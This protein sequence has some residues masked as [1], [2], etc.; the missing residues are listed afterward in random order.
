MGK[1]NDRTVID[2]DHY[3]PEYAKNWPDILAARH[4]SGCPVAW[5]EEHGGYWVLTGY[6][7]VKQA[8]SSPDIFTSVNDVDG[9]RN[10]G[11]GVLI[12]Q[13]PYQL[14]LNEEDPPISLKYRMLE[15]PFFMPKFLKGWEELATRHLKDAINAVIERGTCDLVADIAQPVT[16]KTTLHIVGIDE[17][18]WA[19]FA[20]PAH[21]VAFTPATDPNYP[22][23]AINR[24]KERLGELL[25]ERRADPRD[26]VAS[27]LALAKI[28]DEPL[29]R[30]AA[31]NMLIALVTGGFDTTVTL[32]CHSLVWLEGQPD[33]RERML[34]DPKVMD[35][36]VEECLRAFSPTHGTART[37]VQDTEFF[38]AH[39]CKGDRTMLSWAGANRD[40]SVFE[41]PGEVRIDRPNAK[42]HMAFGGGAHR[43]LG[44]PLAK[45]EVKM[46]LTE[47]LRRLPDYRID[48]DAMQ[49]Y[50]SAG[51]INGFIRLPIA[52]TPGETE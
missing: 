49:P 52:F 12:P 14:T 46:I 20:L 51:L 26:D 1:S 44:A 40:P 4:Q 19:E 47:V 43:C 23:A 31:I 15:A 22:L 30:D 36:A 50:P 29:S 5:S 33:A 18:E 24:I 8:S 7:A 48:R 27:K 28:G 6:D 2:F 17:D 35:N 38:G 37:A 39:L 16:A 42:D 41:N 11:K 13:R 25:D 21:K 32:A 3:S 9:S 45:L 10:G 34:A